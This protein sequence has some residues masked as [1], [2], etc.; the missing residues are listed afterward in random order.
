MERKVKLIFSSA[1]EESSAKQKVSYLRYWMGEQGI[2][3]IKK[4]TALENLTIQFKRTSCYRR[5]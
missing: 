4:L 2:P 5:N 3:L 1:L